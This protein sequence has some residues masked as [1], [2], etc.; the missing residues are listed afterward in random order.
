MKPLRWILLAAGTTGAML[1]F[2]L[3]TLVLI[4]DREFKDLAARLLERQGYSFSAARFGLALPFG[5][6]GTDLEISGDNGPL[7][8]ASR[9]SVRLRLLPL[10]AGKVTFSYQVAIAPGSIKGE[11]ALRRGDMRA[12]A[13][14][15]RLE[16]IP[17]FRTVAGA[18]VKGEMRL[19]SSFTGAG[20][21]AGG[22][23]R[24]EIKGATVS[25]VKIG[26]IPLP[27]ADY[28]LIQGMIRRKGG[29]IVLESFTLQGEGLYVR[30]KGD[31]PLVTPLGNAP[32]NLTLELMPNPEFLEKQKFVFLL[33]AKYLV[34]PGNY[35][36]PIRGALTKPLIQ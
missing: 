30:L 22:E 7:L 2:V 10:L 28:S 34:S 8:K 17:F 23:L 24:L 5:F 16:D 20:K 13:R 11:F 29:Q 19:S 3:L 4:P 6:K 15:L 26:E 27:D 31:F 25:G 18:S 32:L 36:I 33:L 21:T 9:A 35:Q 12:E 1:L 14:G